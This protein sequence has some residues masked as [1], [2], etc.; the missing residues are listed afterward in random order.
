MSHPPDIKQQQQ[1]SLS[2]VQINAW[3]LIKSSVS[4]NRKSCARLFGWKSFSFY[5]EKYVKTNQP[6]PNIYYSKNVSQFI[7]FNIH[8]RTDA[9]ITNKNTW[10]LNLQSLFDQNLCFK[11]INQGLEILSKYH[12]KSIKHGIVFLLIC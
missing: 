6:Y 5:M 10:R 1:K 8:N 7:Y 2:F 4:S 11:R 12:V 9:S 3:Y